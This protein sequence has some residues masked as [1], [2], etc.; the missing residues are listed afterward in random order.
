MDERGPPD[1]ERWGK[2][3]MEVVGERER[4]R[5]GDW[6]KKQR[7]ARRRGKGG[8]KGIFEDIGHELRDDDSD[9]ITAVMIIITK[10]EH[11]RLIVSNSW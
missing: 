8:G 1:D 7:W 9:V 5:G 3:G 2:E 4:E 6:E 10:K 11:L